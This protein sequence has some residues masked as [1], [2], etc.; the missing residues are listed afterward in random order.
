[1]LTAA[2][3]STYLGIPDYLD[4]NGDGKPPSPLTSRPPPATDSRTAA[5]GGNLVGWLLMATARA[6]ASHRA[7]ADL[8]SSGRVGL[9]LAQSVGGLRDAAGSRQTNRLAY[10][11]SLP[12]HK[13]T[14]ESLRILGAPNELRPTPILV[15]YFKG[16]MPTR[17][18][19]SSFQD[20]E[21]FACGRREEIV[22]SGRP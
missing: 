4:I 3:C 11:A 8:K 20:R 9:L 21:R 17:A 10:A 12:D 6:E 7:L 15:R 13:S 19:S 18:R 22:N 5:V 2:G 1:V 16:P 14:S